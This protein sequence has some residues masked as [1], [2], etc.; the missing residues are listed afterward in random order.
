MEQLSKEEAKDV[1]KEA[2]H[3]WLE[4]KYAAFGRWSLHGFLALLV[5][6]GAYFILAANGW[7]K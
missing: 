5:A 1:V 6:A 7:H 4:E 2:L 3:E